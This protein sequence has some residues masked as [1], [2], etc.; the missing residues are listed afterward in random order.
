LVP[1]SSIF[2]RLFLLLSLHW[3][4]T[5][6]AGIRKQEMG[7]AAVYSAW[8]GLVLIF[9]LLFTGCV[10][11]EEPDK[12]AEKTET[13]GDSREDKIT[14]TTKSQTERPERSLKIEM[15]DEETAGESTEKAEEDE[16][17]PVLGKEFLLVNRGEAYIVPEDTVIGK[18]QPSFTD[19]A[20]TINVFE[21]V[22]TFLSYLSAGKIAERTIAPEWRPIIYRSLSFHIERGAT[23]DTYRIGKARISG[24]R[25]SAN[26]R[27]ITDT[28][29]TSGEVLLEPSDGRW[30]ITEIQFDLQELTEPYEKPEAYEPG[31]Y[32]WLNQY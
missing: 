8:F 17:L 22:D 7:R 30:L 10:K 14:E 28:G 4:C 11:E 19:E 23:P 24:G 25:G 1:A 31:V 13:D 20:E 21:T 26:I 16:K 32:R 27:L 3:N 18:L 12:M 15:K 6:I 9:I 29:R 2:F 5:I